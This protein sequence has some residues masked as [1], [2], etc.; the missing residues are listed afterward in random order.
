M[1]SGLDVRLKNIA[2]YVCWEVPHN[3]VSG[4]FGGVQDM[5]LFSDGTILV[6]FHRNAL[7]DGTGNRLPYSFVARFTSDGEEVIWLRR[8]PTRDLVNYYAF[9]VDPPNIEFSDPEYNSYDRNLDVFTRF[10]IDPLTDTFYM[11]FQ[12]REGRYIPE[13]KNSGVQYDIWKL[14]I[15]GNP[16]WKKGVYGLDQNDFTHSPNQYAGTNTAIFNRKPFAY[17]KFNN[18]LYVGGSSGHVSSGWF[19]HMWALDADT[20]SKI[21]G[22]LLR[23]GNEIKG[24][25]LSHVNIDP[26]N[27]DIW[28]GTGVTQGQHGTYWY[29]LDDNYSDENIA[30]GYEEDP[31]RFCP[32]HLI[33]T[34]L[35]AVYSNPNRIPGTL[36]SPYSGVS[37]VGS[38]IFWS[39]N[40]NWDNEGNP[41]LGLSSAVSRYGAVCKL[42]R[43]TL[44]PI[45]GFW[46]SAGNRG[47]QDFVDLT[48]DRKTLVNIALGGTAGLFNSVESTFLA[49]YQVRIDKDVPPVLPRISE[50]VPNFFLGNSIYPDPDTTF[51]CVSIHTRYGPVGSIERQMSLNSEDRPVF[52]TPFL[53]LHTSFGQPIFFAKPFLTVHQSAH[54]DPALDPNWA[55]TLEARYTY[56]FHYYPGVMPSNTP[57][58]FATLGTAHSHLIGTCHIGRIYL[59]EIPYWF[60]H[61]LTTGGS[62]L[63]PNNYD[64]GDDE[65][66]EGGSSLPL[67]G[68]G[69]TPHPFDVI[70]MWTE[71]NPNDYVILN[72]I[73]DANG[74]PSQTSETGDGSKWLVKSEF[75]PVLDNFGVPRPGYENEPT[76]AGIVIFTLGPI[77]AENALFFE[78]SFM[79]TTY[80]G[81]TSIGGIVLRSN[82]EGWAEQNFVPLKRISVVEGDTIFEYAGDPN[83]FEIWPNGATMR[84]P[85]KFTPPDE[86]TFPGKLEVVLDCAGEDTFL[87]DIEGQGVKPPDEPHKQIPGNTPLDSATEIQ[88]EEATYEVDPSQKRPFRR[89]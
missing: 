47:K 35:L 31:S 66:G 12:G 25:Y 70:G 57:Y 13:L 17:N 41:I 27:G 4:L 68:A 29:I 48:R 40:V 80:V 23:D 21:W 73:R 50:I 67:P 61:S 88:S 1:P 36:A 18:R 16:I 33:T 65:E 46:H 71:I 32:E 11:G 38:E 74:N 89:K 85:I 34:R 42:H 56:E 43:S 30:K 24:Q 51:D 64:P 54:I 82:S 79:P 37:Q 87:F 69:V 86:G 19:F 76:A 20:G 55:S 22:Y 60:H 8:R 53:S 52:A 49:Y 72:E 39:R 14:D 6:A 58:E 5:G 62:G 7:R 81:N 84:F 77:C 9:N 45:W 3:D 75:S 2:K 15:D 10:E 78:S 63:G 26:V 44:K 28:V 83:H 59:D